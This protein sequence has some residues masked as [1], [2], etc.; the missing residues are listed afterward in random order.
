MKNSLFLA[1][2]LFSFA[3]AFAQ[4]SLAPVDAGSKIHF[5]IKNFGINT[6]G[7]FSGMAGKVLFDPAHPNAASFDVTVQSSTVDTDNGQRDKHLRSD[8]FFAAEQF[9]QIRLKS[10]SVGASKKAGEYIFNGDLTIRDVTKKVSFIFHAVPQ[11]SGFLFSGDFEID[12]LDYKVGSSSAT[13]ADKVKI[14]LS[15][16]AK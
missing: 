11:D 16:L 15:V 13:M 5:V 6:G 10:S 8:D 7:D 9:P 4:R 12:R 3:G 14:S 2:L 1:I